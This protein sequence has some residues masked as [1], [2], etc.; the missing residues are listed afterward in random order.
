MIGGLTSPKL[1]KQ[2]GADGPLHHQSPAHPRHLRANRGSPR[3]RPRQHHAYHLATLSS[4]KPLLSRFTGSGQDTNGDGTLDTLTYSG[5]AYAPTSGQYVLTGQLYGPTGQPYGPTGQPLQHVQQTQQL[6]AGSQPLPVHLD[7]TLVGLNGS[8]TYRLSGLT[9]TL[10][11]DQ[12]QQAH[13]TDALAG[14][15]GATN[16]IG[17]SADPRSLQQLWDAIDRAGHI[18][19]HGLYVS[20]R[21]HL[22]RVTAA[23]GNTDTSTAKRELDTFISNVANEHAVDQPYRDRVV[24]YAQRVRSTFGP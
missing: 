1:G 21:N 11:S 15:F 17:T 23:E 20:E 3:R 12:S 5:Q 9:L 10:L 24:A 2:R 4:S 16:W 6:Q 19:Q 18:R 13:T 22:N 7:G 14:P 8:G